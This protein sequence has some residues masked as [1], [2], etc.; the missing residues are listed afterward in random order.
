[1]GLVRLLPRGPYLTPA[2]SGLAQALGWVCTAGQAVA[3]TWSCAGGCAYTRSQASLRDQMSPSLGPYELKG[4]SWVWL[5]AQTEGWRGA[6]HSPRS[7]TTHTTQR[8]G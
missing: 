3:L 5:C 7:G 4:I 2:G 8:K 1:M 6:L